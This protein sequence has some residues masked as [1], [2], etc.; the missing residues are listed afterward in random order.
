MKN[1]GWKQAVTGGALLTVLVAAGPAFEAG[2]AGDPRVEHGE[3]LYRVH[4]ASC[5]GATA[6]GDGPV[7]ADLKVTPPD[8]TRLAARHGG[9]FPRSEVYATID[10]RTTVRAHGTRTMPVWGLTFQNR[11]SDRD[12]ERDVDGRIRDLVAFLES[13]QDGGD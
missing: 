3:L 5:H 2:A 9:T 10:G 8:L 4:C 12:Q 1:P 6:R 13:I 7:A 11:G